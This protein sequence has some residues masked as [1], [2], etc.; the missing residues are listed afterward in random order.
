MKVKKL[1]NIILLKFHVSK[2]SNTLDLVNIDF[3]VSIVL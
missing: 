2:E 3:R 1:L